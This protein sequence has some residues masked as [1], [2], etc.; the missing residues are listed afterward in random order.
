MDSVAIGRKSRN[1]RAFRELIRNSGGHGFAERWVATMTLSD[2]AW[3]TIG[4]SIVELTEAT[5]QQVTG[6]IA[7]LSFAEWTG[8]GVML[9]GLWSAWYVFQNNRRQQRLEDAAV[10]VYLVDARFVTRSNKRR[11]IYV[12][13]LIVT[14][15]SSMAS[16]IKRLTLLLEYGQEGRPTSLVHVPHDTSGAATVGVEPTDAFEVP[17]PLGPGQTVSGVALFPIDV[18]VLGDS[19]VES[20]AVKLLDARD[21]ETECHAIFLREAE[22]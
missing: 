9:I 7:R 10:E 5:I 21:R 3:A 6:G 12:F 11:R 8:L 22:S 2:G 16:S 20:Y 4:D 17:L 14:N 15:R 1:L 18:D 19:T 13:K